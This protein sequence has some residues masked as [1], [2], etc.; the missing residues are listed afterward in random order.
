M[1]YRA[2]LSSHCVATIAGSCTSRGHILHH[3]V[4]CSRTCRTVCRL[5][6]KWSSFVRITLCFAQSR[7]VQKADTGSLVFARNRSPATR[8]SRRRAAPDRLSEAA[9]YVSRS[10][11]T[12]T[13]GYDARRPS[14][15]CFRRHQRRD[16]RPSGSLSSRGP[17]RRRRS[18]RVSVGGP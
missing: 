18:R 16:D 4:S 2:A 9:S 6:R 12:A 11:T 5:P 7:R 10:G 1:I 15:G 13:P 17:P 8:G 3:F 14:L